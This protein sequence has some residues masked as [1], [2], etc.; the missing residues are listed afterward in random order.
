M[1]SR[2]LTQTIV[3]SLGIALAGAST[4]YGFRGRLLPTR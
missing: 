1:N 4:F 2:K 3:F